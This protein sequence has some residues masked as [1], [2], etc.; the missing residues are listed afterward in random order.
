M[1]KILIGCA[2]VAGMGFGL[3]L[4]ASAQDIQLEIGPDGLRL[5][6]LNDGCNPRYE[7]C[8]EDG[9]PRRSPQHAADLHRRPRARQGRTHGR[10]PRPHS[11]CRQTDDRGQRP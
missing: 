7:D 3:P 9:L 2:L 11:G 5:N 10:S 8:R 4:P 6:E 1:R